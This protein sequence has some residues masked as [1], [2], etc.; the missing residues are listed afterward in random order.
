MLSGIAR[1]SAEKSPADFALHRILLPT[2]RAAADLRH[3][4]PDAA[5]RELQSVE[6]YDLSWD[7]DLSPIYYRGLAYLKSRQPREAISQFQKLLAH[8][9]L[10]PD[11]I[12]IPLAHLAIARAHLLEGDRNRARTEYEAFFESWKGADPGIPTLRAAR[13]EYASLE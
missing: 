1:L 11:T 5:L 10:R 13:A 3:G 6:P 9:S 7:M 4:A 2:A 8:R 12:H